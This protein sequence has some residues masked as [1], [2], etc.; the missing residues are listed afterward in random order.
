MTFDSNILS[1]RANST[2]W[3][4]LAVVL[5]GLCTGAVLVAPRD[6]ARGESAA[7]IYTSLIV[8][9]AMGVPMIIFA[10]RRSL[11]LRRAARESADATLILGPEGL[12]YRHPDSP[13]SVAW[14]DVIDPL[15]A[16]SHIR[17]RDGGGS[18]LLIRTDAPALS[19]SSRR[20]VRK[21]HRLGIL[22]PTCLPEVIHIPLR[23]LKAR[24]PDTIQKE[25]A[26]LWLENTTGNNFQTVTE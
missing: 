4:I 18:L 23:F 26:R 1:L 13:V 9:F 6:L 10:L 22:A 15:E 21:A 2:S 20:G 14:S 12:E 25:A 5:T 7:E 11:R 16:A 24:K 19:K 17:R 3:F 8:C